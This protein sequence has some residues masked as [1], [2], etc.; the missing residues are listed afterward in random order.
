METKFVQGSSNPES[1]KDGNCLPEYIAAEKLNQEQE[2]DEPVNVNGC[3][4]KKVHEFYFINYSPY[5]DQT[6][7]S[8][9]EEA[10]K[11]YENINRNAWSVAGIYNQ[12]QSDRRNLD[13]Q[14]YNLRSR[15]VDIK[16]T[17]DWTKRK[18]DHLQLR[19]YKLN[20]T[21][22]SCKE[23][24][25]FTVEKHSE[26]LIQGISKSRG[27][28]RR[29][30]FGSYYISRG[31]MVRSD[32]AQL[33]FLTLRTHRTKCLATE[34]QGLKERNLSQQKGAIYPFSSVNELSYFFR[35]LYN[36]MQRQ[37]NKKVS[38][39]QIVKEIEQLERAAEKATTNATRQGKIGNPLCSR[40]SIQDQVRLINKIAE[41]LRM[42]LLK[43]M[44][45]IKH[46]GKDLKVAENDTHHLRTQ[47]Y[48]VK[49]RSIEVNQNILN[50]RKQLDEENC[51]YNAVLSKAREVAR[52]KNVKALE[53]LSLMLTVY[54]C[55]YLYNVCVSLHLDHQE[56]K[57]IFKQGLIDE[58]GL[59]S[60]W[61]SK[62]CCKW[63]GVSCSNLTGH[64]VE[65]DLQFRTPSE[66]MY[67]QP[68]RD[69][70]TSSLL[71]L[72]HFRGQQISA[73]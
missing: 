63:R 4:E 24:S 8:R 10:E 71:E 69:S 49:Q 1:V 57:L 7:E 51:R 40:K 28:G 54:L 38:H 34:N 35:W 27:R 41:E 19:L 73:N 26:D 17:L 9:I 42:E 55:K 59:L 14:M 60:S 3:V 5:E 61:G 47:F 66:V 32:A 12:R 62:D 22:N 64:V 53:E 2:L 46:V 58:D 23:I 45:E 25:H 37:A 33:E 68:L 72:Q 44:D 31:E 50:L 56:R 43:I 20:I 36:C 65:L 29:P 16:E 70:I 30:S 39:K 6:L 11:L 52:E 15:H 18:L 67:I 13:L 48:V 21:K